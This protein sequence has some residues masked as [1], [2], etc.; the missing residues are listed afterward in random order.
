MD[1]YYSILPARKQIY[2]LFDVKEPEVLL[3]AMDALIP[4]WIPVLPMDALSVRGHPW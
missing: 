1:E 2:L 4:P 3:C